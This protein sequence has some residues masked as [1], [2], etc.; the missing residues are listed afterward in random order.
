MVKGS[1]IIFFD[2]D[3]TICDTKGFVHEAIIKTF[4]DFDFSVSRRGLKKHFGK[5]MGDIFLGVGINPSKVSALVKR[6]YNKLSGDVSRDRISLCVDVEPLKDIQKKGYKFIVI[7]NNDR[8]FVKKAL[9]VLGVSQLFP[10]VYGDQDFRSKDEILKKLI[11]NLKLKDTKTLYVGDRFSDVSMAHR[12][13]LYAVAI[14]NKSSISTL[15]EVLAQKPDYIISDFEG[16]REIV[17]KKS[18][19]H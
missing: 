10:V 4:D 16:L 5:K 9:K 2:F 6:I 18:P 1:K 3:G 15:E 19:K 14:H 7:T 11:H 8:K 13:H 17:L 12:A